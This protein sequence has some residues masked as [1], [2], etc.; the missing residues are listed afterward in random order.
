[1]KSRDTIHLATTTH[2]KSGELHT[3]GEDLLELRNVSLG[4]SLSISESVFEYQTRMPNTSRLGVTV[5]RV[6]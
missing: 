5:C 6:C 4:V 2:G 1:M 3:Y